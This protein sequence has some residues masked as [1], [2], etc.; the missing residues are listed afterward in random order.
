MP[1]VR[2][3]KKPESE[4]LDLVE[5]RA[6]DLCIQQK[7]GGVVV[8]TSDLTWS[9]YGCME[10]MIFVGSMD[11]GWHPREVYVHRSYGTWVEAREHHI[12]IVEKLKKKPPRQPW[13]FKL[14]YP[15]LRRLEAIYHKRYS[16]FIEEYMEW[17]KGD[18]IG[19]KPEYSRLLQCLYDTK[20]KIDSNLGIEKI[21]KSLDL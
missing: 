20:S 19:P 10:T 14:L 5:I 11:G 8:S 7:V 2:C 9:S 15:L 12:L 6:K 21:E 18:R 17:S 3:V 4:E 1:K 13:R 16:L